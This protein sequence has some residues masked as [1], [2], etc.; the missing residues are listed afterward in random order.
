MKKIK[1]GLIGL[2][3]IG[4]EII[5]ASTTILKDKMSLVAIYDLESKKVFEFQTKL[6][7]NIGVN[8]VEKLVSRSDLVVEAANGKAAK[9][10][11]KVAL[12][13]NKDIMIMSIG[14]ILQA[15][16]LLKEARK[17]GVNVYFPSGAISGIDALKSA[18]LANITS[19]TI[20]TRKSPGSLKGAPYI[21]EKKI[22]LDNIKKET[23]VFDGYAAE[24]VTG[25]PKNINVSAVLSLAGIGAKKTR[26]KIV[27]VPK[28]D[29]NIHEIEIKGDFGVIRTITE[30]V[31]SPKNPKTSYL[32]A[33][34]AIATLKGIVDNVKI[35]T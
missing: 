31:P 1:V 26:V 35:G 33:L 6:C 5:R 30:N 18:N 16:E 34:S 3:F 13:K 9:E 4:G 32:A 28:L 20:T 19:V 12:R 11:L 23:V 14:G 21:E 15:E 27:A 7:K 22:D 2:G 29:K 24:A 8:S 17:R 25:F 10:A